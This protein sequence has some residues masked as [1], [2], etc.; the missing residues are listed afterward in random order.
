M[1][2]WKHP[3]M[4]KVIPGQEPAFALM[5]LVYGRINPSREQEAI[6]RKHYR[7]VDKYPTFEK[8]MAAKHKAYARLEK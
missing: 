2:K 7:F 8:A 6:Y 3:Y 4:I 5:A 1:S